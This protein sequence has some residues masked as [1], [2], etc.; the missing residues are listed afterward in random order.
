[1][2]SKNLILIAGLIY[3]LVSGT[4]IGHFVFRLNYVLSNDPAVWGQLGDYL[5]GVLNPALSFI[6]IFLL[7]KS[8]KLQFDAN[9]TLTEEREEIKLNEK[10]RTFE[11]LF[12]NLIESRR[13]HF[14]NF[15]VDY[16]EGEQELFCRKG[17]AVALVDEDLHEIYERYV[18]FL[19]RKNATDYV[20]NIDSND[21]IYN[22]VRSFYVIVKITNEKLSDTEGFS[23]KDRKSYISTL[24]H[25]TDLSELHL[26]MIAMQFLPY[27]PV[28]YLKENDE[29]NHVLSDVKLS[30]A[31]YKKST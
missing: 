3:L 7:I 21:S 1:M 25:M 16:V 30:Y 23:E 5:G 9:K 20:K 13:M 12:F 8:L 2:K 15:Q 29:F 28:K 24:I 19:A 17:E 11:N 31:N 26:I 6:S 10:R 14:D 22:I 18:G 27:Y 4:Y